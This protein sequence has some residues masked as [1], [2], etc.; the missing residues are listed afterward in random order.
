MMRKIDGLMGKLLENH[1]PQSFLLFLPLLITSFCTM[2]T[3]RT[4][5]ESQKQRQGDGL[6]DITGKSCQRLT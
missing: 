3:C 4:R 6:D 5:G 2:N 1:Q